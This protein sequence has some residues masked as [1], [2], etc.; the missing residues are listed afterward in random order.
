MHSILRVYGTELKGFILDFNEH[1]IL[2]KLR[3]SKLKYDI[4]K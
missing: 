1:Y 3:K 4:I 2:N